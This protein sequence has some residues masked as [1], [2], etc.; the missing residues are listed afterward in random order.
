[1]SGESTQ[2]SLNLL[3]P[4]RLGGPDGRRIDI[5]SRK[6]VALVAMLATANGGE[7]S[8]AWLQEKLWGSRERGQAQDS[9]RQ[10][11]SALKTCL[12]AGPWPLLIIQRTQV[13]LDLSRLR[14]DVRELG[15]KAGRGT[16]E[17]LEGLDLP[18]EEG[19][20]DW[21]REMRAQ[22]SSGA[23][24]AIGG[25]AAAVAEP[26]ARPSIAVLRF[27][28]SSTAQEEVYLAEGLAEEIIVGLSKSRLLSV[29]SRHSS[30]TFDPKGHDARE[31]CDRL[32]VEYLVQGH[33]RRV[34]EVIRV[35][36]VLVR[37]AEDKTV[38]SARYDGPIDD[39]YAVQDRI[40]AAIIGT[41]EP[42]LL[43]YEEALS[44]RSA[45]PNPRHWVLFLRG[46]WHFWRATLPDWAQAR[47]LLSQANA[48]DPNDVP[49]LSLLA[50]C[51]LGEVWGGAAQD[52]AAN[53][54][55][56][57]RLSLRAVALDDADAYA[58]NI[59]GTVLAFMDRFDQAEAEQHR[60][61]EL[62]PYLAA[63]LGELGRLMVFTGRLDE[64]VA[65]SDR[66]IA[67]S[68]NDPHLFLW[69]RTKALAS[70]AAGRYEEAAKHAA[71]ACVRSPHQFFLHYMLAACC[72]A[73][74]APERARIAIQEGWR[75]QPHYTEAMIRLAC[76]FS[77]AEPLDR[78]LE[79]LRRAGWDETPRDVVSPAHA[80]A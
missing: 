39:L 56:A 52:P 74:G 6:G 10:E 76:P 66:A 42:A 12:N 77:S 46:R 23:A 1:M 13:G 58:H 75:L 16:G 17:F 50:L 8:R 70:F 44:L 11:L 63:A 14:I 73:A 72:S 32:G 27:E 80:N 61:L 36:T 51:N 55:E 43:G 34:G 59:L 5:S 15:G 24:P 71:D 25:R 41:V 29:T 2:F 4:F 7:H 65:Y 21:L 47:S 40:T 30:L 67:G 19:F 38:W 3:G 49:T 33:I 57:H 78:Y 64:A 60:A 48:L 20:E 68:P 79:A 54:A 45:P 35:S 22:L 9:L 31:I 62:N 28:M 53:I 37:G 69:F 18:G 26:A